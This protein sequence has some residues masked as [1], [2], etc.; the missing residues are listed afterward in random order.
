MKI[1]F[2]SGMILFL[3][4]LILYQVRFYAENKIKSNDAKGVLIFMNKIMYQSSV[5]TNA[6]AVFF[7]ISCIMG[8]GL[9]WVMGESYGNII[10]Y[11][12]NMLG[13]VSLFLHCRFLSVKND[14]ADRFGFLKELLFRCEVSKNSILIWMARLSYLTSILIMLYYGW[15]LK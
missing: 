7:L 8:I 14:K 4:L 13:I 1:V 9:S 12:I 5:L 2:T 3:A 6:S 10:S 15:I 11:C